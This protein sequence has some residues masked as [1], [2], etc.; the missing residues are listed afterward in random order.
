MLEAAM[1]LT[2]KKLCPDILLSDPTPTDPTPIWEISRYIIR[3]AQP[4]FTPYKHCAPHCEYRIGS[5]NSN[6]NG[7]Y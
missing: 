4:C 6:N 3:R 5:N 7:I 1:L 2:I